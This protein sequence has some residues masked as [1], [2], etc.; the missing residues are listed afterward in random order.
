MLYQSIP[1]DYHTRWGHPQLDRCGRCCH[2][3]PRQERVWRLWCWVDSYMWLG[4]AMGRAAMKLFWQY[5]FNQPV[6]VLKH[7]FYFSNFSPKS[8]DDKFGFHIFNWLNLNHQSDTNW[9]AVGGSNG[10]ERLKTAERLHLEKRRWEVLLGVFSALKNLKVRCQ[11]YG[12]SMR[13][14]GSSAP[15]PWTKN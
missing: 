10:R 13:R 3:C 8:W 6:G 4:L 7:N 11:W 9:Q 2:P 14:V 1:Y 5:F 15:S 12:F